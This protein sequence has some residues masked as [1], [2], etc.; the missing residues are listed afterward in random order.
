M[1]AD[2]AITG[3]TKTS[4]AKNWID[5]LAL[6]ESRMNGQQ[7]AALKTA[8]VPLTP[9]ATAKSP[10]VPRVQNPPEKKCSGAE[11][12]AVFPKK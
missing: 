11:R 9:S 6:E 4:S 2:R 5:R 3:T 1:Q 7:K 8:C 10:H 12:L